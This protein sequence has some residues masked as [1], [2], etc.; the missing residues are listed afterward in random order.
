MGMDGVE[1]VM[2]V[3]EAFDIRIEDSEAETLLT[4]G[5]LI[6]HVMSK[7][8]ITTTDVCLS[9]RAFYLLRKFFVSR[10][11]FK[12]SEVRPDT[13]LYP[14]F[15]LPNRRALL[16]KLLDEL[17]IKSFPKLVRTSTGQALMMTS[18]I[19][20]TIGIP[21]TAAAAG[22]S[23]GLLVPLGLL[24]LLLGGYVGNKA[25]MPFVVAFPKGLSTAGELSGWIMMHKPG[26]ADSVTTAWT[27]DQVA[28]SVRKIVVDI[29]GCEKIYRED[30][31]FV[32]DLGLD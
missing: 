6:D 25:A 4:P 31:R 10:R 12:R 27:R 22:A 14:V 2:A 5:Q 29:L 19:V 28:A 15:P 26:L 9:Q 17:G 8:A 13:P 7:L 23:T 20:F 24:G 21:I 18:V 30:A 16:G 32:K 3:E 11:G 1:I